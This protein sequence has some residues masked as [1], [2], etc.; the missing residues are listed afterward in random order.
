[1]KKKCSNTDL[2]EC[3]RQKAKELWEKDGCKQGHD[4][5]YWLQTEKIVKS[6]VKTNKITETAF[7]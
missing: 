2:T 5:D 6:Q 1:M 3:I 4:L 7:K